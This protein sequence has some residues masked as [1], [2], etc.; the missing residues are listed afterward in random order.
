MVQPPRERALFD[1][2]VQEAHQ[3]PDRFSGCERYGVFLDSEDERRVLLY[4]EWSDAAAF[5]AFTSSEYFE[6]SGQQLFPLLEGAP[7]AA[8][9][10]SERVG[11]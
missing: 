11:P 1:V 4:E 7:D 2:L 3:V 8:Y 5:A 9:Y 6:R 10:E